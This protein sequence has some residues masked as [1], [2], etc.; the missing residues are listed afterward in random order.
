MIC[1]P[2]AGLDM[3]RRCDFGF[4]EAELEARTRLRTTPE[5]RAAIFM[6]SAK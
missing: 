6:S 5:A 4:A 2:R 1:D 3:I